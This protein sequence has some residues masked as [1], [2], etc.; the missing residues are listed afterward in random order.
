MKKR[1]VFFLAGVL[2]LII[3]ILPETS[4]QNSITNGAIN[5]VILPGNL[6]I[7]I[8]SPENI[9]YDVQGACD[10][11]YNIN[12]EVSADFNVDNWKYD[13]KSFKNGTW[14]TISD[15]FSPNSTINASGGSNILTVYANASGSG[16]IVN[17]SVTFYINVTNHFPLLGS[18]P[19]E[20]FACE[21]TD[22]F[23]YRVNA[24]DCDGDSLNINDLKGAPGIFLFSLSFPTNNDT[25]N[26]GTF[27]WRDI[28]S[29]ALEKRH[30]ATYNINVSVTDNKGGVDT[31]KTIIT[32]IEINNAPY[33]TTN[34]S[35]AFTVYTRGD[36]STFYLNASANDIEDGGQGLGNLSYNISFIGQTLFNIAPNGEMLYVGN[37][38]H[39][40]NHNV[41]ICVTDKGIPVSRRHANI[42]FCGQGDGSNR[43]KCE[44]FQITVTNENRPPTIISYF[45]ENLS[46]A[47]CSRG[48]LQVNITKDESD[49]IITKLSQ[50][51]LEVLFCI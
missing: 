8:Y 13:L 7:T 12:L 1:S 21:S 23:R 29:V 40:G 19:Q 43:S 32:V 14:I 51:Y 2:V 46:F 6:D 11:L 45:P 48:V 50:L 3:L 17:K 38:S 44:M 36:D 25:S 28:L 31:N 5:L 18:L 22:N 35:G 34:I 33:Y 20:I 24:T 26:G 30:V 16:T 42:S 10:S 9:S 39:L 41:T 4:S 15:P 27:A 47:S 37:E 49:G